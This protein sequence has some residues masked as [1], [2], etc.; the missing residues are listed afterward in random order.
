MYMRNNALPR[1]NVP[2]EYYQPNDHKSKLL[3][4][5]KEVENHT[6]AYLPNSRSGMLIVVDL[7]TLVAGN[8]DYEQVLIGDRQT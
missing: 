6:L 4:A 2:F 5:L 8:T 3:S 7:D 1:N